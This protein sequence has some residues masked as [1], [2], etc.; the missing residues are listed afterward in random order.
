MTFT[1]LS[2]GRY[3]VAV[4]AIAAKNSTYSD[5]SAATISID[6]VS[7]I[8]D[9][10]YEAKK[11]NG[12]YYGWNGGGYKYFII[13]S[14]QGMTGFASEKRPDIYYRFELY[15][16]TSSSSNA[17]KLPVGEY[18]VGVSTLAGTINAGSSYRIELPANGGRIEN[19]PVS[20]KIT[21]TESGIDV[22]IRFNDGKLHHVTY[23]GNLNLGYEPIN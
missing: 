12:Q 18:E 6:I 15:S 16:N 13:L 11:L 14:T 20:G 5:S 19:T 7:E 17:P 1:D 2:S 3:K 22:M 8:P 21:V 9:V 4:T 10:V 23:S